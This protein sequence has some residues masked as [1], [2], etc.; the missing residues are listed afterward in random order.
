MCR[1][2]NASVTETKFW[3][4]VEDV[5]TPWTVM[6]CSPACSYKLNGVCEACGSVGT[7]K[8]FHLALS[9]EAAWGTT[10]KFVDGMTWREMQNSVFANDRVY[11]NYYMSNELE[12]GVLSPVDGKTVYL[13]QK[14]G[15]T[16]NP[17]DVIDP[18]GNYT[19]LEL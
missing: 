13:L 4:I 1:P 7:V 10:I 16:V 19:W 3:P 5:G 6:R 11:F 17:S 15:K 9:P 12:V 14:N 2:A 18:A 8:S